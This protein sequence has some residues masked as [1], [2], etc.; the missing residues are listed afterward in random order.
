MD[1]KPN[2]II[3]LDYEISGYGTGDVRQL[4][5]EPTERILSILNLRRIKMTIF[6]ELEVFQAF[7]KYSKELKE[8]LGYDP[9]LLIEEQLER[10]VPEVTKL[11]SIFTRSGLGRAMMEHI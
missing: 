8:Q 11:A 10:M 1:K 3:T 4:V 2:I 5:I 7:R 6:F 9:A